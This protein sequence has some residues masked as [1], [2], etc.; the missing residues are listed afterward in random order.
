[1][2]IFV[3][4]KTHASQRGHCVVTGASSGIGQAIARALLATGR[5]VIG[6]DAAIASIDDARYSHHVC[7]LSDDEQ[8]AR[9]A[10]ALSAVSAFVHAA[11]LLRVG[12]HE[13]SD[14]A[15]DALMWRV[16]V[17][18][19]TQLVKICVPHMTK[20]GYGR[21]VLL[22]SRVANG[23]PHRGQYA[24]TKAALIS[25]AR[26]WAAEVV[27]Q[28]VT[29]NVVSPAVT[30][31]AMLSDAARGAQAPKRLPIGRLISP[32]EVAATVCFLISDDAAAIT[33]QNIQICGGASLQY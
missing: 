24:A 17:D 1:M 12:S 25:L 23:M 32:E 11:G 30:E 16:H 4:S 20:N 18:A 27:A 26:S 3:P 29:I 28:G 21:V 15:A 31:T 14:A 6:V 5:T 2:E 19:A 13:T 22:G 7:D 33:G 10:H 8:I 9:L